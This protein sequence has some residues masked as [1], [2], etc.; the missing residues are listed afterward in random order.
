MLRFYSLS[1]GSS[2]NSAFLK[3]KNSKILI[4]CGISAKRINKALHTIGEDSVDAILITHEHSDHICG[5]K[6][7][8]KNTDVQV[9]ATAPT[10]NH[11]CSDGIPIFNRKISVPG[12]TFSVGDIDVTPFSTSHDSAHPVGYSLLCGN[13]KFVIATDN[14]RITTDFAEHIRGSDT[15]L[16][17]SNYDVEM[18]QSGAYPY[19]LKQ[20]IASSTGHMS[21]IQAGTLAI[22][23]ARTGTKRIILGHLSLEN[24]TPDLAY[25]TVKNMLKDENLH[26]SLTV[27]KRH[28][29]TDLLEENII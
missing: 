7:Y 15:A 4:D 22:S 17:E 10:W 11:L 14:G 1:S 27:A 26:I 2:G 8:T 21:N 20:R 25:T 28:E 6:V 12:V 9:Y 5:L 18:L 29:I 13:N 19:S 3:Y 16:I 24:N 23:L